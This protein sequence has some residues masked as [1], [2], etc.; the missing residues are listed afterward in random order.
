[1]AKLH[2]HYITNAQKELKYAYAGIPDDVFQSSVQKVLSDAKARDDFVEDEDGDDFDDDD[3]DDADDQ[4]DQEEEDHNSNIRNQRN[5]EIEN[6]IDINNSELKRLLN[7]EV[8]VV[9]EPRPLPILIMVQVN[10]I[11]KPLLIKY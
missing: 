8:N 2:T 11:L 3:K 1:M 4:E 5:T 6:W 10:L 7:I 9:I